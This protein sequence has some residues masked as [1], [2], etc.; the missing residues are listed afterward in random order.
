M[1]APDT[2]LESRFARFVEHHVLH[3]ERLSLDDLCGG[4]PDL[5][6]PLRA[7]VERYLSITTTLDGD[8]V[9][10]AVLSPDTTLPL[11]DGFQTIERIG[12]GG[13]GEV[14]KLKD[15]RLNRLVAAKVVRAD[16]QSHWKEGMQGFLREA[17]ALTS[18]TLKLAEGAQ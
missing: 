16:R 6:T 11:F 18:L 8:A 12:A 15:L 13:M 17:R 2:D 1:T 14:F 7:L 9:T 10:P 4:R 5:A 3:G